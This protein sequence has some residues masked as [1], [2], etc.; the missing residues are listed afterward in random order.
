[1]DKLTLKHLAAYLPYGLKAEMI[2]YKSDYVGKKY[3][4]IIGVHQWDKNRQYWSFLTVG[5][6]KP[7]IDRIKP[8][9]RPLSQLTQE[10]VHNEKKFVPMVELYKIARGRYKDSVVKY[11]SVMSTTSIRVEQEGFNNFFFSLVNS[12]C[13][14]RLKNGLNFQLRSTN[15]YNDNPKTI[16]VQC[17]NLLFEKL[18]EW[19]FDMYNLINRGLAVAIENEEV[20]NERH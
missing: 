11:W 3:D 10:I 17:W 6:S 4:E 15:L 5:G 16:M 9:L 19:H 8:I 14:V 7:N 1:M 2:D 18:H 12:D 13:D 20:N